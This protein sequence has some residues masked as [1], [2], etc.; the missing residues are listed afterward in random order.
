MELEEASEEQA[1]EE[2]AH[3]AALDFVKET[4][5]DQVKEVRSS[6]K[7]VS[8]PV[9]LTAGEGLSFEM[10]K[11]FNSVQPDSKIKA[12]RILELNT[13]HPA[14]A[15]LEKAVSEDPEKAGKYAKLFYD[16]ALLIAGLPIED[17]A[18]YADLVCSLMN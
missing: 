7:L 17:P 1:Q 16:Q 9:C 18:E 4:L 2:D 11:Y 13:S 12:D 6:K 5:G 15:A 3:K 14:F 10:E 8:H